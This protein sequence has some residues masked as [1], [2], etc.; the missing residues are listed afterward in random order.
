MLS[1]NLDHS[2]SAIDGV[3]SEYLHREGAS[4]DVSKS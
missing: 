2:N 1:V 4:P 3:G